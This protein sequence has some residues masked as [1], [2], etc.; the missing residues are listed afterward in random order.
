VEWV[1]PLRAVGTLLPSGTRVKGASLVPQEGAL[2]SL[3]ASPATRVQ[4]APLEARVAS[5]VSE[6]IDVQQYTKTR[7]P[8]TTTARSVTIDHP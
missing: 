2:A 5:Q 6:E 3:E 1:P 4:P 7:V 8:Q